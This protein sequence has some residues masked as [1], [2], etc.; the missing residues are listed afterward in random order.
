M[1]NVT[2]LR[3]E[4]EMLMWPPLDVPEMTDEEADEFW[5]SISEGETL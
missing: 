1:D 2:P 4:D 3:P 5:R